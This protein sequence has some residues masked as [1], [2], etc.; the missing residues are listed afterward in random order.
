MKPL[1][2]TERVETNTKI[3]MSNLLVFFMLTTSVNLL[4]P[5]FMILAVFSETRVHEY[6]STGTRSFSTP[7]ILPQIFTSAIPIELCGVYKR[8]P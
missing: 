7:S 4:L 3:F 1:F 5:F 8:M 6:I 2:T